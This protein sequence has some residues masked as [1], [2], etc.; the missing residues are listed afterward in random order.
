VG[1][2]VVSAGVAGVASATG[3]KPRITLS[4]PLPSVVRISQQV[5]V[6]GDVTHRGRVEL[7]LSRTGTWE[8][9]ARVRSGTHG[10]FDLRWQLADGTAIG[11]VKLRVVL[12][13]HGRRLAATTATQS[14][15]G[16]AAVYCNPPRPPSDVPAGDGWIVGGR[17]IIGGAFPGV[18]ECSGQ[19]YT[20][21]AT[22]SSG[23]AAATETVP[24]DDSY[25]LVVPAG[26]Y[27]LQ[28][29]GCRGS[30]TATAGQETVADTDCLVP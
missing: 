14:A 3:G 12:V 6:A 26:S 9:V 27:T 15:I 20:V 21:T 28:S 19:S 4:S 23:Q 18:D 5:S 16:P 7:E 8:V 30:A 13:R 11:P 10:A 25:A 29:D 2:A 24:A 1:A 22:G 17:Y